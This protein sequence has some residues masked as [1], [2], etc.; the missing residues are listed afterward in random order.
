MLGVRPRSPSSHGARPEHPVTTPAS[1]A[2]AVSHR[3]PPDGPGVAKCC[4]HPSTRGLSWSR[5]EE[6]LGTFSRPRRAR[7]P[8]LG[9]VRSLVG[10]Y[11]PITH[12]RRRALAVARNPRLEVAAVRVGPERMFRI[13]AARELVSL[14]RPFQTS[15]GAATACCLPRLP[16]CRVLRTYP[17]RS[18]CHPGTTVADPR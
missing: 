13:G 5:E 12:H 10:D 15:P 18:C 1:G 6:K 16:A 3:H 7:V 2:D 8:V 11:A 17:I 9:H 14:V 4:P